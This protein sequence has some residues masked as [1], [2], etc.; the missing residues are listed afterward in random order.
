MPDLLNFF[1]EAEKVVAGL[2]EFVVDSNALKAICLAWQWQKALIKSKKTDRRKTC[3]QNEEFCLHIAEGYLQED[4]EF[5]KEQI[6]A[7]LEKIVQSSALVECINS[8]IRPY[9]NGSRNHV[10]QEA[11]NL[12]MFY[13]NHRRF[14]AGKREGRTPME[15]LTGEK[16][17]KDW[18]DLL[19][20][21]VREKDKSFS[22]SF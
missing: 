17:K 5:V 15:I 3:R 10:N 13:H 9:L 19:F 11:L 14:K 4:L 20:E 8:I 18:I 7:Q 2:S 6:Y 12:I 1:D 16:Q 21:A 22:L